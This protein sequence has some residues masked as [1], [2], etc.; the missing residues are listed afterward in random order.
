[1]QRIVQMRHAGRVRQADALYQELLSHRPADATRVAKG[2]KEI[3]QRVW[4]CADNSIGNVQGIMDGL[5]NDAK[6]RE[7]RRGGGGPAPTV[8]NLTAK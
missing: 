2:V 6:L 1:M 3:A 5:D 8:G 4:D 7:A